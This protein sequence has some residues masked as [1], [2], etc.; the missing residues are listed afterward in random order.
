MHV[1][2]CCLPQ[3]AVDRAHTS[4]PMHVP[5]CCQSHL[6]P[7]SHNA[8]VLSSDV[9]YVCVCLY[10]IANSSAG[11]ARPHCTRACTQVILH[12]CGSVCARMHMCV[13][14]L[15]AYTV[16]ES[17][18]VRLRIGVCVCVCVSH[19]RMHAYAYIVCESVC[20]R[21][22]V[23]VCVC[24]LFVIACPWASSNPCPE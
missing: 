12:V 11:L 23:C 2:L 22:H 17:I 18:C 4:Y 5:L 19:E 21:M 20:V 15:H 10:M 9:R 14:L 1:T 3:F 16:C 6:R 24:V 7:M 8:N 13:C